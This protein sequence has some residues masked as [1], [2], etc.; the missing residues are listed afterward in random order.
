[1]D[2]ISS[3]GIWSVA[4]CREAFNRTV[5]SRASTGADIPSGGAIGSGRLWAMLA[6]S[7]VGLVAATLVLNGVAFLIPALHDQ[8]GLSLAQAGLV[9]AA[10]LLGGMAGLFAW[11]I[12]TDRRGERLVLLAGLSGGAIG[13]LVAAISGSVTVLAIGFGFAGFAVGST[14]VA[15]GRLIVGW[16]P[17]NRRG[18]AMG[19]RQMAQPTGVGLGAATIAIT[20][21][22]HG[23]FVAVWIPTIACAVAA[24]LVA[25]VVA[26]PSRPET[27]PAGAPNPYR[28]QRYLHRVHLI[29]VLLVVPQILVW[30]F[31][32][33]WLV[34]DRH[35]SAAAAGTLLAVGQVGGALGRLAAGQLSDM[36]ASRMRPVRWVSTAAAATMLLLGITAGLDSAIA[37]PLLVIAAVVTVADNGVAF[38]AVA[39]RAGP[40]WSGRAL[41][42]QNTGQLMTSAI[43][44]PVAGL[45]VAAFGFPVTF[46]LAA[47]FPLLALSLI[48]LRDELALS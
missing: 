18:L 40:F 47:I 13:G 12:I 38:T 24:L 3:G 36:V 9:A 37:I 10:P 16:F 14:N 33:V 7:T 26:D 27:G 6:T 25:V 29:S 1:M 28:G 30:S 46:A 31:A 11:G 44:P 22:R 20:A 39:E 15:S 34:H 42:I 23:V 45:T 48:P 35:W 17:A 21:E 5:S 8:Y 19:V 2:H 41:A 4:R 32:L 43:V